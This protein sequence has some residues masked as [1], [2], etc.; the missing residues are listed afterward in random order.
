MARKI[1]KLLYQLKEDLPCSIHGIFPKTECDQF[2]REVGDGIILNDSD[3]RKVVTFQRPGMI[4][5]ARG[6]RWDG[7]SPKFNVLDLFWIGTPD[8][9][10]IGS[11]RP[12]SGPDE[13]RHIPIT[14]ERVTQ[15]ASAVHDVL[16]YCKCDP[17]M[18]SLFR[19]QKDQRDLWNSYGRR[20]RDRLFFELLKQKDHHPLLRSIYYASIRLLGPVY[21]F[22]LGVRST[23]KTGEKC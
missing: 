8:G 14:H 11:E 23:G 4:I 9:V 12:E 3:G 1:K 16:G 2:D 19:A 22:L 13:Y 10:I 17:S 18:P 15:L 20:N 6:Y 21:D 5:V 7:C